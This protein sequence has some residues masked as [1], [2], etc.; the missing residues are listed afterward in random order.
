MNK[1]ASLET[2]QLSC[3]RQ[4]KCLFE[5]VSF[6]LPR[7]TALLIEGPNG[8]GKSS[9]LRLIAGI[10]TPAAGEVRWQ[11][12]SIQES[13]DDYTEQLHYLG[14]C[15]GIKSGLSVTENLL[16]AGSL[17]QHAVSGIDEVLAELSLTPYL[18]TQT[19]YLSAGQKR[20][21]ALARLLLIPRPLWILD[22]PFTSL[23]AH[24]QAFLLAKIE[25]H[26][27]AGGSCLMTSHQPV[28]MHQHPLQRMELVSC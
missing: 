12:R 8:A 5:P 19:Q 14:H 10:A 7:G 17:A 26:L 22:E 25:A 24:T 6:I 2:R 4:N 27:T 18:N 1:L 21:V 3:V 23:D 13:C 11:G 28:H 9:L 20:R 15:N 16:L